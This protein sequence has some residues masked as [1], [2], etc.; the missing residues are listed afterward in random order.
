[1][2]IQII[3]ENTNID[4]TITYKLICDNREYIINEFDKKL[5]EFIINLKNDFDNL[6][7]EFDNYKLSHP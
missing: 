5:L 7:T 6:K 4:N 3:Q 1:M 2:N